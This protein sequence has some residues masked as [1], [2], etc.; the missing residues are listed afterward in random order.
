MQGELAEL[1]KFKGD[2][3]YDDGHEFAGPEVDA[4]VL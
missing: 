4:F 1:L 3:G 2:Y